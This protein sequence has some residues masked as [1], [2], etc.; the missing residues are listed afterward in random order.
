MNLIVAA[1]IEHALSSS[2]NRSLSMFVA[3]RYGQ[4]SLRVGFT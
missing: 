2:S 1:F 4:G 3:G